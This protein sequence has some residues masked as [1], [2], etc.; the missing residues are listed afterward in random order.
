MVE[1]YSFGSSDRFYTEFQ[2]TA[3]IN[4]SEFCRPGE[5]MCTL[6]YVFSAIRND[7]SNHVST[8]DACLDPNTSM[9]LPS[10]EKKILT[11]VALVSVVGSFAL[12]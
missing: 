2:T 9:Q 5:D 10:M 6:L 4:G 3:L 11:G 12:S 1:Y 7:K 8:M